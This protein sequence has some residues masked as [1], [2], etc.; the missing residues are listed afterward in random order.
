M[1]SDASAGGFPCW[2][3]KLPPQSQNK[4]SLLCYLPDPSSNQT[5]RAGKFTKITVDFRSKPPFYLG[6][7][8]ATPEASIKVVESE[9]VQREAVK[10][11][12]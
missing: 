4:S 7:S 5:W 12:P 2:V 8:R 11:V 3:S 10:A 1:I 9:E 6:I